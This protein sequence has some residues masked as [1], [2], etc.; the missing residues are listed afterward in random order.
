[1]AWLNQSSHHQREEHSKQDEPD[2]QLGRDTSQ[3]TL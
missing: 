1:V 3:P 2:E